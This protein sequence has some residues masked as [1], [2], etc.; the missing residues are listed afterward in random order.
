MTLT[1][2]NK[3][4]M[5]HS[6][7]NLLPNTVSAEAD[8]QASGAG[9]VPLSRDSNSHGTFEDAGGSPTKAGGIISNAGVSGMKS[10]EIQGS[11]TRP[12]CCGVGKRKFD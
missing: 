8:S 4:G 5:D 12:C 11:S 1:P 7:F 10:P 9:I 3:K 2:S 6:V